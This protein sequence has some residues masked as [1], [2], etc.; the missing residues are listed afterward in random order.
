MSEGCL[1]DSNDTS[2]AAVDAHMYRC[3][4]K[5]ELNLTIDGFKF[6]SYIFLK[7]NYN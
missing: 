6:G 1:V 3:Y 5:Q 4:I 7:L 2:A